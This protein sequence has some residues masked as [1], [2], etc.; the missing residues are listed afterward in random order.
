MR[1]LEPHYHVSEPPN[2]YVHHFWDTIWTL[3]GI[4]GLGLILLG[5]L[6]FYMIIVFVIDRERNKQSKKKK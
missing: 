5:C 3:G 1:D 6:I 4:T 2:P